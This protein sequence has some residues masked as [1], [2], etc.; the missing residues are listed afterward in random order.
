MDYSLPTPALARD[1]T[2]AK[3][4]DWAAMLW[5][6]RNEHEE[7]NRAQIMHGFESQG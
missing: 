6:A 1:M 2:W 7:V 4:G 5:G 3:T